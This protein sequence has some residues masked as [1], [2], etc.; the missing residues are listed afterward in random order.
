MRK[1]SRLI[2]VNWKR[3]D[4][5]MIHRLMLPSPRLL[6][7][8]VFCFL[9]VNGNQARAADFAN[10]I[11]E[12]EFRFTGMGQAEAL[13]RIREKTFTIEIVDGKIKAQW[14]RMG[15]CWQAHIS[16]RI[17]CDYA[18]VAIFVKCVMWDDRDMRFEGPIRDGRFY[19]E[20]ESVT[21]GFSGPLFGTLKMTYLG[22]RQ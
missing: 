22:S 16:G 4:T 2:H 6:M 17:I 9:A 11:Y 21:Y 20:G 3:A 8:F 15:A 12:T 14:L 13:V 5:M 18:R 19:D 7:L 10:G 1:L